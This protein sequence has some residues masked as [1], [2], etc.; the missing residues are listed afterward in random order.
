MTKKRKIELNRREFLKEAGILIGVIAIDS[1]ALLAA[2]GTAVET[3]KTVT[4][5]TVEKTRIVVDM[6]GMTVEVPAEVTRVVTP[7]PI[8]TN[9]IYT[10]QG[11]DKLVGIDDNSPKDEWL[12]RI[13]PN[14]ANITNVGMPWSVN[15]ETLLSLNPDVVIGVSGDV[16]TQI[17]DMGIP[18]IGLDLGSG[19]DLEAAISLIGTVI[20]EEDNAQKLTDYYK[21]Q[22]GLITDRTSEIPVG[23]RVRVLCIGRDNIYTAAIG[24]CYQDR[25]IESGGGINVAQGLTGGGWFIQVSI[26]QILAW[27][28]EVILVPPYIRDGSAEAILNDP[29][30]QD[31]DAV[32]NGRVYT[33][34]DGVAT[35][36]APEPES[37][38]CPIWIAQL[39]YPDKFTDI[40]IR[41]AIK[42][43]YSEFYNLSITE[44]DVDQIL[45]LSS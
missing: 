22:M 38:L 12:Q 35:W 9:I 1:T 8:A 41:E 34:P 5:T 6:V 14:V 24:G 37:F 25:M 21:E 27:N 36:D 31:I 43:F 4:E 17:E 2:C 15:I 39:L 16:R 10:L 3:T 18:V 28:P 11:Q 32:K 7:Y 44:D 30:W 20:N 13:D 42:E 23:E 40:D 45:R 33:I 26:E 19:A 29:Q